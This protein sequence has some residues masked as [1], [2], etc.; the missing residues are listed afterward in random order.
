MDFEK[1]YYL[2]NYNFLDYMFVRYFFND[3]WI[4]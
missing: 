1:S 2:I 4:S 3:K